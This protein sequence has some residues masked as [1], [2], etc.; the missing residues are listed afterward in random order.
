MK[1]AFVNHT[2][3]MGSGIDSLIYQLAWRLGQRNEVEVFTFCTDYEDVSGF[4]VHEEKIP[5][6]RNRVVRQLFAPLFISTWNHLRNELRD[7]DVVISQIYPANL[8]VV[9]P[10]HL[11][12]P[13]NVVVEWSTPLQPYARIPERLYVGLVKRLNGLACRK[14]DRVLVASGFVKSL[15]LKEWK[16]QA[17]RMYLDGVDFGLFDRSKASAE[18]V[19]AAYP[20]MRDKPVLLYVGQIAPHKNLVMLLEAFSSVRKTV[21]DAMLVIVGSRTYANYYEQLVKL[22][23]QKGLQ[24]AV[25]FTGVVPWEALPDYYAACDVYVTCSLWEG[26]LRGEAYAL[27]RPMVAFDVTSHSDSIIDGETGVL[28][29]EI[30]AQAF[31][32][33]VSDLLKNRSE[34]ERLGENGYR[35]ARQHLDLD[36]IAARLDGYLK[37]LLNEA[38]SKAG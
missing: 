2:F 22:V 16:V 25:V 13:L 26:F 32:G 33:P 9:V 10:S 11:K 27:A 3:I 1:I 17:E 24:D 29:R 12:G 28:V 35:W 4:T 8:A 14:A 7:Y 5:F 23:Q 18:R 6:K 30:D 21:T 34:R 20:G 15:V 37:Q 31:A 38:E 19:Y 36:M